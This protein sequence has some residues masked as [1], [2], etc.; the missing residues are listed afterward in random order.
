MDLCYVEPRRYGQVWIAK[1]D[2]YPK[3]TK[4]ASHEHTNVSYTRMVDQYT[5]LEELEF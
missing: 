3:F 1:N 4:G 5:E 2:M